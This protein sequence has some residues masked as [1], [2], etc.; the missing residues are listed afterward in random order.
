MFGF[1]RNCPTGGAIMEDK[2]KKRISVEIAGSSLSLVT[3]ENEGFVRDAADKL[4]SRIRDMTR[5]NC[6][7][8]TLDAALLCAVDYL[9]GR[10]RAEKRIRS[11]EAQLS[12]SESNARS[13][14]D[15]LDALRAEKSAVSDAEEAPAEAEAPA[16]PELPI[17]AASTQEEKIHA[18]ESYLDQRKDKED[19]PATREEKIRYIESLLRGSRE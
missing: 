10:S 1:S 7:V 13:L 12:L 4:D 14:R 15:E 18:L 3:D 11:L 17:S 6:R 2:T 5:N 16:A 9:V 8:N 19:A